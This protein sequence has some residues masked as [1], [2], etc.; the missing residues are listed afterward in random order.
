VIDADSRAAS[1]EKLIR[2]A[3]AALARAGVPVADAATVARVLVAAD[4]RGIE[5]HGCAR[6]PSYV[7]RVRSGAIAAKPSA[8]VVRATPSSFVL[9]AGNGLGPP[10]ARRAMDETISRARGAG[11]A[12]GAVSNSN[13]FG[14]A[15][16]Y[17]MLALE[18]DMIGIAA[19][20]APRTTAPT[21]GTERAIGANPWAYAVPAGTEPPFVLDFATSQTVSAGRTIDEA[22]LPLGGLGTDNGGH[23]G[24][25][26]GLL[27]DVMCAVLAGGAFG[28]VVPAA[29][30]ARDTEAGAISHFFGAIR[31]DGFRDVAGFKADMDRELRAFKESEPAPGFARVYVAG[32]VEHERVLAART[33]GI[34]LRATIW[35]EL[36][37]LARELDLPFAI[38]P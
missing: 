2:F 34:P 17:A 37:T 33:H 7:R 23:K 13:H 19:T 4:S 30:D 3:T 6:L 5:A 32:E 27:V 28:F 35:S 25:G 22:A 21:F 16:Y 15:G 24:Y 18:H 36:A 14:I 29:T 38:A 9:D 8:T 10:A 12:F 1:E 11:V 31:I 26:L 20:N